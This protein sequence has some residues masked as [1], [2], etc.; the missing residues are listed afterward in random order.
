[1]EIQQVSPAI[2]TLA[3]KNVSKAKAT[4]S[5]ESATTATDV[6]SSKVAAIA[7]KYD[8]KHMTLE[9]IPELGNEL[10]KNGLIS[11]TEGVVLSSL[12]IVVRS[13]KGNETI[14]LNAGSGG[15]VDLLQYAKS[16][17]NTAKSFGKSDQLDGQQKTIDTLEAMSTYRQAQSGANNTAASQSVLDVHGA[18][19]AY[20]TG[21]DNSTVDAQ[22]L[23]GVLEALV[24]N[25]ENKPIPN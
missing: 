13:L 4:Q 9:Q 25:R 11:G 16:Q 3:T 12:P 24:T 8:P 15:T 20:E 10:L 7:A 1:M 22:R 6:Y 19:T 18:I 21:I 2:T 14:G 17:F 5:N 23:V